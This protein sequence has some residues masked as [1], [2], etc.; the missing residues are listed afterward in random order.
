MGVSV[1]SM[2][3]MSYQKA[4]RYVRSVDGELQGVTF[5]LLM[6][7][8]F[9]EEGKVVVRILSFACPVSKAKSGYIAEH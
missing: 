1:E 8:I 5:P 9:V 6:A 4:Y 7:I 3:K 2:G